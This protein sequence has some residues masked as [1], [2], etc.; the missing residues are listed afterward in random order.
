MIRFIKKLIKQMRCEHRWTMDNSQ[1]LY[2]LIEQT[3][4]TYV[5]CSNCGK[6]EPYKFVI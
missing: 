3:D 4:K 5:V 2:H 1:V 6:V